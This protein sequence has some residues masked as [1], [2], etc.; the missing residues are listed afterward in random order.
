MAVAA[1]AAFLAVGCATAH[2]D[3]NS[4]LGA[5]A[6]QNL[7]PFEQHVLAD[8]HVTAAERAQA[9]QVFTGCL[10]DAGIRYE[11]DPG[12]TGIAGVRMYGEAAVGA[13]GT[14]QSADDAAMDHCINQVS[15]VE[16]VWILQNPGKASGAQPLPGLKE[17]LD[18][19]DTSGW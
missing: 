7:S 6:L 12:Q 19:L 14:T 1:M 13:G 2:A 4:R 3:P 17:A 18:R 15:A 10:T 11:T 8:K 5:A 9:L 16:N